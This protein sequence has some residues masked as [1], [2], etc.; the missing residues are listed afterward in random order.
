MKFSFPFCLMSRV[1]ERSTSLLAVF[2][3]VAALLLAV[4][5]PASAGSHEVCVTTTA[6]DSN[7]QISV[8]EVCVP[9]TT[10]VIGGGGVLLPGHVWCSAVFGHYWNG[11][12]HKDQ[13]ASQQA[14]LDIALLAGNSDVVP[15]GCGVRSPRPAP[16]CVIYQGAEIDYGDGTFDPYRREDPADPGYPGYVESDPPWNFQSC[17]T[18]DFEITVEEVAEEVL[19]SVCGGDPLPDYIEFYAV[20]RF[21]N[22]PFGIDTAQNEAHSLIGNTVR[23]EG[24]A[25]DV[26]VCSS[27]CPPGQ[28]TDGGQADCH[29]HL[30]P[31]CDPQH[32]IAFDVVSGEGHAPGGVVPACPP[33]PPVGATFDV[34]ISKPVYPAIGGEL[35]P[36][37]F[38]ATAANFRCVAPSP[39]GNAGRVPEPEQVSFDIDLVGTLGYIEHP[40]RDFVEISKVVTRGYRGSGVDRSGG[41]VYSVDL[42][43]YF[44]RASQPEQRVELRMPNVS[45]SYRYWDSTYVTEWVPSETDPDVWVPQIVLRTV[46]KAASMTPRFVDVDGNPVVLPFAMKVVGIISEPDV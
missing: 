46:S 10:T 20:T 8:V 24:D 34:V 44:Y 17:L 30:R 41:L 37:H 4:Q 38:V 40:D 13:V 36:V 45:G 12:I 3:L 29:P 5:A 39:C 43:A 14:W 18:D 32:D 26:S 25:I 23:V 28:H 2:G 7:G 33:P 15:A 35:H 16:G 31:L 1:V 27:V 6:V 19:N 22:D 9:S 42:T 21:S 11:Q